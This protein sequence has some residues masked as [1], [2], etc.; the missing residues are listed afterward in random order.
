MTPEARRAAIIGFAI[1]MG[2][3]WTGASI[4]ASAISLH[5]GDMTLL[6]AFLFTLPGPIA[7]AWGIWRMVR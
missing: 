1:V 4:G 5:Y 3:A 2:T 6:T 7:L